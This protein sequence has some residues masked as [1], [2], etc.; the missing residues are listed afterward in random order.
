MTIILRPVGRGNWKPLT[1]TVEGRRASPIL[2][3][4]NDRLQLGGITFRVVEVRA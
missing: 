2:V 4:K 1:I 3:S